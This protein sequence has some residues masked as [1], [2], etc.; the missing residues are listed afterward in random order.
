[1]P[2][3]AANGVALT[4][5]TPYVESWPVLGRGLAYAVVGSTIEYIGCQIDRHLFSMRAA[6]PIYG[7]GDALARLSDGCVNFKRSAL[8]AG[9]GLIA[10]KFE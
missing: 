9:F 3:Y 8:W 10:E 4:A 7:G 5:L 6:P 1:M 2:I